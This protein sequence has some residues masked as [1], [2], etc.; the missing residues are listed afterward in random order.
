MAL[1]ALGHDLEPR[2][3]RRFAW[4]TSVLLGVV[5]AVGVTS[6]DHRYLGVL[7]VALFPALDALEQLLPLRRPGGPIVPQSDG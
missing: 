7:I 2:P 6:V 5:I 4:L 3:E 1:K